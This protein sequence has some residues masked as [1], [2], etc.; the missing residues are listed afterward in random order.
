MDNSLRLNSLHRKITHAF[1]LVVLITATLGIIALLDLMFLERQVAEG[2]VVSGLNDSILEMRRFEK[3]LFLYAD[4]EAHY[5]ADMHATQSIQI[6]KKNYDSVAS[7][8]GVAGTDQVI[9]V[10]Q[11]YQTELQQWLSVPTVDKK[12]T[13][14]RIRANGHNAYLYSESLAE[15][16]RLMLESAIRESRWFLMITLLIIGFSIYLVGHRLIKFTVKP[17][18]KLQRQLIH[19]G[20]GKYSHLLSPSDDQEFITFTDAFNRMLKELEVRQKRLL[21]AEK[22]A[23]L[24]ILAS[25]V[26]HELNNPLSN[27]STSCQLLTEELHEADQD[28]LYHWLKQIDGETLRGQKIVRAL[29]DFGRQKD[30]ETQRHQLSQIIADT[31]FMLRKMLNQSANKME[32]DVADSLYVQVDNQRIQQLFINLMQNALHAGGGSIMLRIKAEKFSADNSDMTED[33]HIVGNSKCLTSDHN[34]FVKITLTDDGPGIASENISRIFDPFY[35]TS[36]PGHGVGLGLYIVQEIVNEH[37]GCLA[38]SST[39]G[40]GTKV[41]ILLP[42]A[43]TSQEDQSNE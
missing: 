33:V 7:I 42:E 26:A 24:G 8:S 41:I 25:G 2:K 38:I 1:A 10:L 17:L 32:V 21:H 13:E 36:E 5:Q 28:Q 12:I 39:L 4:K 22:L 19:L 23:S 18:K 6:L 43:I 11:Q 40:Q 9:Q 34:Q 3:N 15:K 16:E 27:I 14:D 30:F 20:E 29:L 31:Q 37:D 35:T